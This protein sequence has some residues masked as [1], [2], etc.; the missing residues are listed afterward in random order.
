MEKFGKGIKIATDLTRRFLDTFKPE[1]DQSITDGKTERLKARFHICK[2]DSVS[3]KFEYHYTF[4][5]KKQSP[6]CLG[7]Y[8]RKSDNAEK[9]RSL[10]DARN[11]ANLYNSEIS[12]GFDPK[13]IVLANKKEPTLEDCFN[14]IIKSSNCSNLPSY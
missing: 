9:D 13:G 7:K 4:N 2:D 10:A 1:K 12:K 5:G 3:I 14:E 8:N 11:L 6:I